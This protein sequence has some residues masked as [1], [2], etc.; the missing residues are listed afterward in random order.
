MDFLEKVKKAIEQNNSLLCIGLDTDVEKIPSHLKSE[1]DPIFSFNKLIIDATHDVVCC[2]KANIAFYSS[3]GLKG[4]ESLIKTI[5]YIHEQFPNIPVILDA[6]RADTGNTSEQYAK[7]V[8]DVI[9]ADAVTVNPY[10]G[11]D[12]IEPFLKRKEKGVIVLCKTSNLGALDFQDLKID[13]EPLYVRVAQKVVTWHQTYGNC[14]LVVGATWP[15]E[16]KKVRDH[17]PNMFFLI[18]G[19]GKQGGDLQ[20]TLEN[21]LTADKSGLTPMKSGLIIHSA[22]AI[23]YASGGEDFAQVAREKAEELK[24]TINQYR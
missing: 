2:Y 10:L 22:R 9:G 4:I 23:I 8:F 7:E 17:A 5:K 11:L 3:Q 6:K 16:L 13:G 15:E 18:P 20:K 24:N 12:S 14:L 19:V 21:G 1:P